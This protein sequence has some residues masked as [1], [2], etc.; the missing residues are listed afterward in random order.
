[1]CRCITSSTSRRASARGRMT[2]CRAKYH[3][4][5]TAAHHCTHLLIWAGPSVIWPFAVSMLI[6]STTKTMR[7]SAKFGHR[8]ALVRGSGLRRLPSCRGTCLSAAVPGAGG[9]CY[10]FYYYRCYCSHGT[11]STAPLSL[12]SRQANQSCTLAHYS[13]TKLPLCHSLWPGH[14]ISD[15]AST[16]ITA[17]QSQI[18][19]APPTA[20]CPPARRDLPSSRRLD[21]HT[22]P[23][24]SQHYFRFCNHTLASEYFPIRSC[25]S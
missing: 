4:H 23:N 20:V 15:F 5:L 2:I 8:P 12:V 18:S 7:C 21:Y 11:V 13:F 9:P 25:F 24:I 10:I 16:N 14:W 6:L 1:M 17:A 19:N 22:R 3:K